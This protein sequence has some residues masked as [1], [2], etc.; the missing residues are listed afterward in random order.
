[1]QFSGSAAAY[2]T[3]LES[4]LK[5]APADRRLPISDLLE[6]DARKT[7]PGTGWR[8]AFSGEYWHELGAT[9]RLGFI[10]GLLECQRKDAAS[11]AKFSKAED[12]YVSEISKSYGLRADD[13]AAGD[14]GAFGTAIVDVL[15]RLADRTS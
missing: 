5:S 2:Q 14:E 10:Q 12:W 3:R 11:T 15:L 7:P 9:E 4:R 8:G 6:D 1:V 13:P